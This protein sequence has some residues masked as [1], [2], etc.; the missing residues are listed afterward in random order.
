MAPKI[1]RKNLKNI[2]VRE[3]EPIML[4]IKVLGE[5]P[6]DI[7]W[8]LGNKTVTSS[9]ARRIEVNPNNTKF[10]IQNTERK[11]TGIYKIQATNKFGA[12]N[13][14]FELT[15]ISKFIF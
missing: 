6:P 11:D 10:V 2:T 12:D 5:P 1:E 13:A 3:G 8:T 15:V 7:V 4:D 14:D 9:G